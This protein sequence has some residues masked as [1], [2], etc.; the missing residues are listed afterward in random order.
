M[1]GSEGPEFNAGRAIHRGNTDATDRIAALL[2]K[3]TAHFD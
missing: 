2:E 3:W 1:G